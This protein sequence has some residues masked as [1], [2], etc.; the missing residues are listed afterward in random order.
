MD[1]I[2]S[3]AESDCLKSGITVKYQISE[4]SYRDFLAEYEPVGGGQ[5][6][7]PELARPHGAANVAATGDATP[8]AHHGP[9]R[10]YTPSNGS[11]HAPQFLLPA[12]WVTVAPTIRWPQEDA[13]YRNA[14]YDC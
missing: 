1:R 4:V 5:A 3:E 9:V 8:D 7:E 11:R 13:G 2:M 10:Y 14:R 6:Q 12:Q